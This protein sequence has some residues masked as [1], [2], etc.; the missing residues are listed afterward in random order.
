MT[1][2]Q[3]AGVWNLGLE[4]GNFGQHK[5]ENKRLAELMKKFDCGNEI[6]PVDTAAFRRRAGEVIAQ[7]L[8][9][10]KRQLDSEATAL[11]IA[12]ELR[13]MSERSLLPNPLIH[14]PRSDRL[15]MFAAAAASL[16]LV[17]AAG[18]GL[19]AAQGAASFIMAGML[20]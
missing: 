8:S 17:I 15:T 4:I 13:S 16:S 9:A 1:P 18:A 11:T 19:L 2:A 12:P 14:V 5:T 10:P 6:A 7:A 20:R 3:Y